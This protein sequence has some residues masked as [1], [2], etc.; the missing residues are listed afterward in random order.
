MNGLAFG[1]LTL[2]N[3]YIFGTDKLTEAKEFFQ[4]QLSLKVS[5]TRQLDRTDIIADDIVLL[6]DTMINN[7]TIPFDI[8]F[9]HCRILELINF[10]RF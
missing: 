1:R 5:S 4:L 6:I 7:K 2:L 3:I 9:F 8:E 10:N